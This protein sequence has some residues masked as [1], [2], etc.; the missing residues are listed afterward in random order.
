MY[1]DRP[2]PYL[3]GS[4]E[5][6][7]KW[8]IGLVESD[9]DDL[10][11]N[12][13]ADEMSES[14]SS[15]VS[16]P[17]NVPASLS[18]SEQSTWGIGN[19]AKPSTAQQPPGFNCLI[20]LKQ[21][22]FNFFFI[23]YDIAGKQDIFESSSED[24]GPQARRRSVESNS[25]AKVQS[26]KQA[27]E[28]NPHKANPPEVSVSNSIFRPQRQPDIGHVAAS[29]I[30]DEPPE[31]N[32]SPESKS[33]ARKPINLFLD[34]ENDD[35]F[36]IFSE[37]EKAAKKNEGNDMHFENQKNSSQSTSAPGQSKVIN[38]FAENDEIDDF[39]SF[40]RKNTVTPRETKV[41][42]LFEDDDDDDEMFLQPASSSKPNRS[43]ILSN[44]PKKD[45]FYQNLFD[46]EPPEDDFEIFKKP[47]ASKKDDSKVESPIV[48]STSVQNPVKE[49]VKELAK[50]PMKENQSPLA[51]T[52]LAEKVSTKINLFDD[53]D[54]DDSFESL[55]K[56]S[57]KP[58]KVDNQSS[59]SVHEN[60]VAL[61]E[62]SERLSIAKEPSKVDE[63]L[64]NNT[65]TVVDTETPPA[66][67]TPAKPKTDYSSIRLF[68]DTPPDDDDDFFSS[69]SSERKES[70]K[71]TSSSVQKITSEFYN[72]FSE[73][74][75]APPP[76]EEAVSVSAVLFSDE[77]PPDEEI[78]PV[79]KIKAS[80]VPEKKAAGRSEFSKKLD[81]FSKSEGQISPTEAPPKAAARQ[82]KKLN[83]GNFDINVAALLPGAKRAKSEEKS[84]VP[85]ES[86]PNAS[87][88]DSSPIKETNSI[89]KTVSSDNVDSSGRL[90][91]LN[92]NRA[93]GLN[94]RPST[95]QGRQQQYRKSLIQESEDV[96]SIDAIDNQVNSNI[97]I[98][99]QANISEA[100]NNSVTS[101]SMP[102]SLPIESHEG[103]QSNIP[104][105]VV[106]EIQSN[107]NI[108]QSTEK[109]S[110][111]LALFNEDG[112][113][114]TN[115]VHDVGK[116]TATEQSVN[117]DETN[118]NNS[119]KTTLSLFDEN[120]NEN[121]DIFTIKTPEKPAV[122][123]PPMQ[124]KLTP[125]FI[126]EMPP[127][128]DV[129]DSPPNS[130]N[131]KSTLSKNALS[132][133]DDEDVDDDEFGNGGIFGSDQPPPLPKQS[134]AAS[135]LFGDDPDDEEDT[136]NAQFASKPK[137]DQP[138][139]S[140]ASGFID[141]SPPMLKPQKEPV[142]TSLFSDGSDSD[143]TGLFG[144]SNAAATKEEKAA[145]KPTQT[146][147][148]KAAAPTTSLFGDDE[149][150]DD[151][152]F[153]SKVSKAAPVSH[154]KTET[155]KVPP[156]QKNSAT[157]SVL[158]TGSSKLF[159]SD[160]DDD[161][162]FGSGSKSMSFAIIL[163][164]NKSIN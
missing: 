82:P 30:S 23:F 149:S 8:H 1:Q 79:E 35:D 115:L 56:S 160:D 129:D 32:E 93:K 36:N 20:T 76:T 122:I 81:M 75:T 54:D 140:V 124:T 58:K 6:H 63:N 61:V 74:V 113:F 109:S 158:N 65:V 154:T 134:I 135:S 118:K 15:M 92:R 5:W 12:E 90:T 4:K 144:K 133:F 71:P 9:A 22:K 126:D 68:D 123:S 112:D 28:S 17:S 147:T 2:L 103:N 96:E 153:G 27:P 117:E 145:P 18:E 10:S 164:Q 137:L 97:T 125:A 120:E 163:I 62:P 152:L 141:K 138:P 49:P 53:A 98:T 110:T 70:S 108:V 114:T 24:E 86:V 64:K 59:I 159:E 69:I 104:T 66:Q 57:A 91:N 111:T 85:N 88:D 13:N 87:E 142:S 31:L 25:T 16:M 50:E 146:S 161:D 101:S 148:K 128:L 155:K 157:S 130:A 42:N 72:D 127:E 45:V 116:K 99:Q 38:L 106:E 7:E 52:K 43:T 67:S 84:D 83:I 46:D 143:D 150:S 44:A 105:D 121:E 19:A 78:K 47:A 77:P 80:I 139:V 151:D 26:K 119:A 11:E 3:I 33:A 37:T 132:L 136:W 55:M 60:S 39:D 107:N 102:K 156:S 41:K 51:S 89:T 94:R 14:P 21:A 34:D 73:T 131:N 100:N 48:A 29:L 162:L 95:R 40:L